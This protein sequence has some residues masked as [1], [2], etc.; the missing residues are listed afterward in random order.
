MTGPQAPNKNDFSHHMPRS[1]KHLVE[2][3]WSEKATKYFSK[4]PTIAKICSEDPVQEKVY[5]KPEA[6]QLA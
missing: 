5:I 6:V 4:G 1:I 2:E 3:G